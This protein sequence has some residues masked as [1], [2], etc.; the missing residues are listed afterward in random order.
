MEK[1]IQRFE[2][3]TERQAY[4]EA[5]V[6][7]GFSEQIKELRAA[8]GWTQKQLASKM[9]T[10]QSVVSRI[11]DAD[12][13]SF[14]LATVLKLCDAFDVGLN[15]SF[16]STIQMLS[17]TVEPSINTP[18][19]FDEEKDLV[20]FD[21]MQRYVFLSEF[22]NPDKNVSGVNNEFLSKLEI[23]YEKYIRNTQKNNFYKINQVKYDQ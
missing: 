20:V 14:S 1:T 13:Y 22:V 8:R 12:N 11:E 10:T 23:F 19:S 4:V 16:E 2:D 21:E 17:R 18:R 6:I 3:K 5:E 7:I 15:L 9:K